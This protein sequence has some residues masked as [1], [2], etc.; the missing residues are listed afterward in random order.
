MD[1]KKYGL[2]LHNGI[3]CSSEKQKQKQNTTNTITNKPDMEF[4]ALLVDLEKKKILSE[5]T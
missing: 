4:A 2:H 3:L 5:A 1:E